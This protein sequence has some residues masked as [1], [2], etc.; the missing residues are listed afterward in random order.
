MN[1]KQI[2]AEAIERE[3]SRLN[4]L[5]AAS[6]ALKVL[7]DLEQNEQELR[8]LVAV[9]EEKLTSLRDSLQRAKG[10]AQEESSKAQVML[11][12]ANSTANAIVADAQGKAK[13]II[14]MAQ[15]EA[16][17]VYA[18]TVKAKKQ[19]EIDFASMS[20][21]NAELQADILVKESRLKALKD[22]M[23]LLIQKH[24]G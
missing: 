14:E 6:D 1:D 20:K 8:G 22:E 3:I 9:H 11:S 2:A 17:R 13:S 4:G 7:G 16:T 5:R 19:S 24:A 23:S 12:Q 18:E 10:T 15:D 21:R